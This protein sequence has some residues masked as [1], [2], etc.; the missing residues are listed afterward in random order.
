MASTEDGITMNICEEENKLD[1]EKR[2]CL[3][4]PIKSLPIFWTSISRRSH[5]VI[6]KGITADDIA[7][8]LP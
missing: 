8:F 7:V 3:R 6:Q 1:V 4:V 5:S 2:D